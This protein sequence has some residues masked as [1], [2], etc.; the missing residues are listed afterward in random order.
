MA[1][2]HLAYNAG[3]RVGVSPEVGPHG[4]EEQ[5]SSARREAL[6]ASFGT[7]HNFDPKNWSRSST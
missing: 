4:Y 6:S 5:P 2:A 3:S 1:F 7:R